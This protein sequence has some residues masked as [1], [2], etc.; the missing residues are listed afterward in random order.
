[1]IDSKCSKF[2]DLLDSAWFGGDGWTVLLLECHKKKSVA[3]ANT[4]ANPMP[5]IILRRSEYTVIIFL[6]SLRCK[7]QQRNSDREKYSWFSPAATALDWYFYDP[8]DYWHTKATTQR[9]KNSIARRK[10]GDL[11]KFFNCS[12]FVLL[13]RSVDGCDGCDTHTVISIEF[14]LF[15]LCF[16]LVWTAW[17]CEWF[18]WS[19]WWC[20]TCRCK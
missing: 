2:S 8:T 1:M 3:P 4:T 10:T 6:V 7:L 18:N 19:Q 17:N 16:H 15:A 11:H 14:N 9:Q 5:K 12:A 20:S 13:A